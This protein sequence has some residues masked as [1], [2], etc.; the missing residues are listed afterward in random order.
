MSLS[1]MTPAKA[2]KTAD[3]LSSNIPA[4]KVQSLAQDIKSAD[5]TTELVSVIKSYSP[6]TEDIKIDSNI[7]KPSGYK[8]LTIQ[9]REDWNKY[10]H[11]LGKE[12]GSADLDK[13]VPTLGRQKLAAYL[14][15]NPNSSLND[16]SNQE[17]LIKSIQYEMQLIRRGDEFPGL[18]PLELK[19]LQTLMLKDRKPFMMVNR[20]K[21]DGNPGQ[22]TTQ[23]FYPLFDNSADYKSKMKSVYNTLVLVYKIKDVDGVDITKLNK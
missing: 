22:F 23:E 20:S 1:F 16:F 11:S 13:G 9:Q 10:L 3:A 15:A 17:D 2:Q 21:M 5:S 18:S 14:K 19:A 12:R 4:A 6:D 8:P 7:P